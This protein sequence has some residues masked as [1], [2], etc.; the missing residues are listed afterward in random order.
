MSTVVV[1]SPSRTKNFS[2]RKTKNASGRV[3]ESVLFFRGQEVGRVNAVINR[4][5]KQITGYRW[6]TFSTP[7]NGIIG[8]SSRRRFDRIEDAMN[9]LRTA[10]REDLVASGQI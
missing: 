7:S 1:N 9:A 5:S 6:A 8:L 2:W 10:A 3:I 4:Q